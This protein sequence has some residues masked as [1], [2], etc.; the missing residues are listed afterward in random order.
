MAPKCGAPGICRISG[1]ASKCP[2][3]APAIKE[4]RKSHCRS[5]HPL[6]ARRPETRSPGAAPLRRPPGHKTLPRRGPLAGNEMLSAGVEFPVARNAAFNAMERSEASTLSQLQPVLPYN[7]FFR[8]PLFGKSKVTV[9]K[10]VLPQG[11]LV[12]FAALRA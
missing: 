2:S 10:V 9:L 5:F 12:G 8:L 11:T 7:S 4:R 1:A 6:R 3:C